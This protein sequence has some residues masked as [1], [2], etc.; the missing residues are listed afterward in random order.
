MTVDEFKALPS[1]EKLNRPLQALWYDAQGD[2]ARAHEL[3][4]QAGG[5]PGDRVHA[6]LHRKEGDEGNA[7][8]WYHHLGTVIPAMT[9]DEEWLGLVRE[10]LNA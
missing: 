1:P 9:V 3:A 6:Y 4:Q 2:W 7:R 8:Y 5:R 10:F